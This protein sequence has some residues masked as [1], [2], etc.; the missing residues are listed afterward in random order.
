MIEVLVGMIGTGKTTYAKDRAL[1]GAHVVCRDQLE[2]MFTAGTKKY[3]SPTWLIHATEEKIVELSAYNQR[4]IVI[5]RTNLN[6]K[7]RKRWLQ[8]ASRFQ[9][10][11]IAVVFP[12]EFPWV[13]AKRRFDHDPR[14]VSLEKWEEVARKQCF[15]SHDWPVIPEEGFTEIRYVGTH[16]DC[17]PAERML[18]HALE[19]G[20]NHK[21]R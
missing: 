17:H 14:G 3:H 7:T 20:G 6:R 9:T 1:E 8:I 15:E 13:C 19:H 11:I 10:D 12:P 2:E 16:P 18:R 4:S 21:V 5:D